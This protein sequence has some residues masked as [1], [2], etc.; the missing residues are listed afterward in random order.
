M[1][2]P[3]DARFDDMDSSRPTT[4]ILG[5]AAEALALAYLE[6]AGL[7]ILARNYRCA[8][9]EIDLVL[10]DPA[11]P[12]LVL[13]E[14]RSRSRRDFGSAASTIGFA[15]Q[16]RL[17]IAAR[18]LLRCRRDLRRLRVRFDVVA[19]DPSRCPGGAPEITWIRNAFELRR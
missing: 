9:G 13:V 6:R 8:G 2:R 7:Q 5:R 10:L 15:K 11:T 4:T 14:V 16:R 3:V 19:L 18:H 12:V 17:S 1:D